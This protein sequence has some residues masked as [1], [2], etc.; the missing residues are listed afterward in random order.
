MLTDWG[1]V[2]DVARV[3]HL[4]TF[5]E[6]TTAPFRQFGQILTRKAPR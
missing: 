5:L 6:V 3:P 2:Y 1:E 4:L